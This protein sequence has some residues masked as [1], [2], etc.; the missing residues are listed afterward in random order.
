MSTS[1]EC[2]LH[3]WEEL[4]KPYELALNIRFHNKILGEE[5]EKILNPSLI[6]HISASFIPWAN[7]T[8][9]LCF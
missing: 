6:T 1:K 3:G 8:Q 9:K 5:I 2:I 4:S 7:Q